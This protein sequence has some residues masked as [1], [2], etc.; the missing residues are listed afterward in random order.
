MQKNISPLIQK[1]VFNIVHQEPKEI[2][3]NKV[4]I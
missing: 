1:R 2:L 4:K 3:Q